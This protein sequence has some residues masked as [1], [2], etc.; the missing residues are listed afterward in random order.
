[1]QLFFLLPFIVTAA[2]GVW[3]IKFIIL[4]MPFMV[5]IAAYAMATC[6]QHKILI[7]IITLAIVLPGAATLILKDL[8]VNQWSD[9]N[10]HIAQNID[11]N[12]KQ[13]FIYNSFIFKG[14]VDR[15]VNQPVPTMAYY[16]ED[17]TDLDEAIIKKNYI[18]FRREESEI[19]EWI[20]TKKIND[21][22]EIFFL[23]NTLVGIPL[24]AVLEKQGWTMKA[25]PF[26]LRIPES[27][28][29]RIYTKRN[30]TN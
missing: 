9:I 5:V 14:L 18:R 13:L 30:K 25:L 27:P 15:Y 7:F 1:M 2:F 3:S 8:P 12:K 11:K 24:P 22:D 21:Y 4:A 10:K 29:L 23:Y 19:T 20:K 16:M 6:C 28:E 26:A 17:I